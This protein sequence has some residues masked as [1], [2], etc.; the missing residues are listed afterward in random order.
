MAKDRIV[1]SATD[2]EPATL[3]DELKAVFDRRLLM[4]DASG[5]GCNRWA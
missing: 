1:N 4:F 5:A 2:S 3:H